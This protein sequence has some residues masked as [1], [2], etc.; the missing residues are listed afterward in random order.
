MIP[1]FPGQQ[2]INPILFSYFDL[3]TKSYKTIRTDPIEISVAKGDEQFVAVG[4]GGSKE[5]VKFIG[6]DIRFIQLRM[7]EFHQIGNV[8]YK[9]WSF[10]LILIAPIFLLVG[11]YGYSQYLEKLSTNV[12]Y[13]RSR[14]ANQMALKRLRLARK[15][16]QEGKVKEFLT[17]YVEELKNT[18]FL[19]GARNV[20][21][22]TDKPIVIT[23]KT[24]EWLR[25]RGI[26]TENYARRS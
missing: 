24:N 3:N 10:Y 23:G 26:D 12:A 11:A 7:P 13:A 1:R 5:D 8:F 6:Q 17:F 16:M 4:V 19:V 14:K 20:K 21:C 2:V 22:L 25:E 9:K 15:Q 18:M